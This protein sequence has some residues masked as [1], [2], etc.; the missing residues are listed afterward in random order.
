MPEVAVR[1]FGGLYGPAKMPR[2]IVERLSREMSALLNL[3]DV[4]E[5]LQRQGYAIKGSTP[6]GL[7]TITKENLTQWKAAI[8]EAGMV[9]E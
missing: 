3:P 6:D 4:R 2:E 8:R 5:Q 1:H 7:T 9:L